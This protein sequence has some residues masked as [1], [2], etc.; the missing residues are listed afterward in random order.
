MGAGFA[1]RVWFG[2]VTSPY[3]KEAGT[4]F[5]HLCEISETLLTA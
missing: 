1:C 3:N 4:D 5:S 2:Q